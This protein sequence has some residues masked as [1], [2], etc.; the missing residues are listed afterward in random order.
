MRCVVRVN[1]KDIASIPV[2]TS[3]PTVG[4]AWMRLSPSEAGG[5]KWLPRQLQPVAYRL[6]DALDRLTSG[7][8][9][10]SGWGPTRA[11]AGGRPRIVL[12][13]S[14]GGESGKAAMVHAVRYGDVVSVNIEDG[15]VA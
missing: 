7:M 8:R 2:G 12:T 3:P 6:L 9:A 5:P 10:G 4:V 14:A 11:Y 13:I 1:G 15:F